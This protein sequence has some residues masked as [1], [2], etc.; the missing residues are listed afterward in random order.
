[1][2]LSVRNPEKCNVSTVWY[3]DFEDCSPAG[4]SVVDIARGNKSSKPTLDNQAIQKAIDPRHPRD[5]PHW[6]LVRGLHYA[7]MVEP[8]QP[9]RCVKVFRLTVPLEIAICLGDVLDD[10]DSDGI[11]ICRSFYFE[12]FVHGCFLVPG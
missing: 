8:E 12:I 11:S 4:Y 7:G 2:H 1:V 3:E 6:V 5:L 10:G 9:S